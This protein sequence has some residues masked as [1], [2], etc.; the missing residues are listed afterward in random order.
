MMRI[1]IIA[2]LAVVLSM[3]AIAHQ[4]PGTEQKRSFRAADGASID[5][6]ITALYTAVSG[7]AGKKDDWQRMRALFADGA[8]LQP[9]VWKGEQGVSLKSIT[10]DDYIKFATEYFK[11]KSFHEKEIG[12]TVDQFGHIA[13]VFSTYESYA[14]AQDP[15]P[16]ARGINSIQLYHDGGRWW[17]LSVLWDE[18]REGAAI[19]EHY[20]TMP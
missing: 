16:F 11:T 13:Q 4:R 14:S 15:V 7:E 8:R 12:R 1:V 18:E 17:I 9:V 10:V 5:A 3:S 2:G 20:L 19:P 6:I